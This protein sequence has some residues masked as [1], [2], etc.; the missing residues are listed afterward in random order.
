MSR[1]QMYMTHHLNLKKITDN[2]IGHLSR[3]T[4]SGEAKGFAIS[5]ILFRIIMI[6]LF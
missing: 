4:S 1:K 5:F 2:L 6:V 3:L